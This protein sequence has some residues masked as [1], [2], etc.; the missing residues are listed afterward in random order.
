[1]ANSV[2]HLDL[3]Q[4]SQAQ[5]EVTANALY[6]AASP[7][8]TYGRRASTTSAL[9]WGYYGGSFLVAGSATP[10]S[11][12]TLALTASATNYIEADPSNGAVSKNTSG[13]TSGYLK[14]YTV[15]TNASGVTSYTDHRASIGTA[16]GGG[17]G[18]SGDVT[19]PASATDN[20]IAVF[21]GSSGKAIKGGGLLGAAAFKA[22]G[23]GS[24][25]VAA[26]DHT[27]N[28]FTGDSGS[29]GAKGMVPAPGAGDS[30]AGKFLS[31]AGTWA[32]PSGG[33][34][35]AGDVTGPASST[36][37]EV[38]LFNGT[39][40]KVIKGGGA[41]GDAAAKNVGTASGTVAAGDHTHAAFTGDSGSGGV[42]GMVPAPGA[43][44]SAAGKYLKADGTW[45]TPD[46]A[47]VPSPPGADGKTYGMKNGAWV[48]L[49]GG[50][51][52]GMTIS[53]SKA[54]VVAE[55]SNAAAGTTQGT[56]DVR[57]KYG[58]I[59]TLRIT[60]GATGPT[61]PCL[62]SVAV[63]HEDT[64]PSAGDSSWRTIWA[65]SGTTTAN[66][67]I[68]QAF[69]FGPE[70]RHIRSTFTGNTGQAVTVEA[71]ASLYEVS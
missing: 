10:V 45:A 18:G 55:T 51:G 50:G 52:S 22:V 59:L 7:A 62:G 11:N 27:H 56:L 30:A 14:L 38:A 23:T 20:E 2:T 47:G 8:M 43:G 42:K 37:N 57:S 3:I 39:T 70:V 21:N 34:G 15:V 41:L 32:T 16:S 71:I 54:T 13:F 4:Q 58:G 44:D 40:G 26:G 6:D 1:M 28:A 53:T 61:V 60:N 65:Y 66:Q 64:L 5:K 35:G 36:N 69:I 17:G 29:G 67:V 24:T 48:E 49:T 9:T 19:G 46:G 63:S 33:G 31:A 68:T 12:G 25:D